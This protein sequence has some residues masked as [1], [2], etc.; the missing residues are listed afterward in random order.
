MSVETYDMDKCPRLT[1]WTVTGMQMQGR[2]ERNVQRVCR[3][4]ALRQWR[5]TLWRRDR[6]RS[7]LLHLLQRLLTRTL[8]HLIAQWKAIKKFVRRA[9][10][11][12]NHMYTRL[13][14]S[15]VRDWF[16]RVTHQREPPSDVKKAQGSSCS[17]MLSPAHEC[18]ASSRGWLNK[19]LQN[20]DA[21][22]C[23]RT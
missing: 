1:A 11:L 23:A 10:R 13:L 8:Q 20:F 14:S 15:S 19:A 9:N 7:G 2:F 17:W 4:S 18:L 22:P 21:Q 16:V 5:H 6:I 3:Q 12:R